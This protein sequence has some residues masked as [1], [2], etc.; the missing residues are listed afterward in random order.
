VTIRGDGAG[1]PNQEFVLSGALTIVS[2]GIIIASV[3]TDGN[4]GTTDAGDALAD[5]KTFSDDGQA[6]TALK[7]NDAYPY[8]TN[9]KAV[10]ETGPTGTNVNDLRVLLVDNR[11]RQ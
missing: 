2:D 11:H 3:D 10:I 8:L 4:D 7:K 9:E 6:Q 5:R 1:G